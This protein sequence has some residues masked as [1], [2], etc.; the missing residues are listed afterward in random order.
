MAVVLSKNCLSE[1]PWLEAF[2]TLGLKIQ[3][4]K[5]IIDILSSPFD[6]DSMDF[7]GVFKLT[8]GK[9]ALVT[10]TFSGTWDDVSNPKIS[11]FDSSEEALEQLRKHSR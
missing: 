8:N 9:F 3:D 7:A 11:S 10:L 6:N 2:A 1:N 4:V 5:E